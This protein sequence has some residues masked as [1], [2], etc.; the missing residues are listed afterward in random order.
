[1]ARS[2][3]GAGRPRWIVVPEDGTVHVR[4]EGTPTL[5]EWDELLDTLHA[6]VLEADVVVL[7]GRG[8][9]SRFAREM[10]EVLADVLADQGITVMETGHARPG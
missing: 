1:M 7:S 6:H 3:E 5:E 4:I 2:G 8:W 10:A 9:S